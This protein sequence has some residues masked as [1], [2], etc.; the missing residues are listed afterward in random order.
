MDC[1]ELFSFLSRVRM[2]SSVK[3]LIVELVVL[4]KV[5]S[6]FSLRTKYTQWKSVEH[7]SHKRPSYSVKTCS[8]CLAVFTDSHSKSRH[9]A[10]E[11]CCSSIYLHFSSLWSLQRLNQSS[12]STRKHATHMVLVHGAP[13]FPHK[14]RSVL[15]PVIRS[16]YRSAAADDSLSS[17]AS[18]PFLH[19]SG[20]ST[21]DL[22]RSTLQARLLPR[23]C[24]FCFRVLH[25]CIFLGE[26]DM[27]S[28]LL[29]G[30]QARPVR[31]NHSDSNRGLLKRAVIRI[32]RASP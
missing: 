21:F 26:P 18:T 4:L 9:F 23:P 31:R 16:P 29:R 1:V 17:Y 22:C 3:P 19:H 13:P 30:F 6:T 2:F 7:V 11:T 24:V 25:P 14:Q 10:W 28:C 27:R 12:H 8:K 15:P 5:S 20:A 32:F